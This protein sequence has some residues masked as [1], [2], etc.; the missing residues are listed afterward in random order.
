MLSF[1]ESWR[2][3]RYNLYEEERAVKKGEVGINKGEREKG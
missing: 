3:S 2:D 1:A